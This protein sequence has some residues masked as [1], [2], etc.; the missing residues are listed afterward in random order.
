MRFYA[1]P[2]CQTLLVIVLVGWAYLKTQQYTPKLSFYYIFVKSYI[3]VLR[4]DEL[5]VVAILDF[6]N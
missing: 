5:W 1:P 4:F 3:H 2:L 6:G